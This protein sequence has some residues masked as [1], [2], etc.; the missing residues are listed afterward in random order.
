MYE[1][2]KD[3]VNLRVQDVRTVIK[4]INED[5]ENI[6]LKNPNNPFSEVNIHQLI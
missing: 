1:N 4:K 3:I 2:E 5:F 6:K